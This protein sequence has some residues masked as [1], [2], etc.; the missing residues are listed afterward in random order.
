M[1]ILINRHW[2]QP[3]IWPLKETCLDQT[4][5]SWQAAQMIEQRLICGVCQRDQRESLYIQNCQTFWEL[6]LRIQ[7]RTNLSL[8]L[9]ARRINKFLNSKWWIWEKTLKNCQF[10][11]IS[12]SNMVHC[13]RSIPPQSWIAGLQKTSMLSMLPWLGPIPVMV[14]H[15]Y[16][17]IFPCIKYNC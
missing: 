12:L 8:R 7:V 1:T 13:L 14:P 4:L 16:S 9:H 17:K 3:R 2:F 15:H 10:C 11:Q 6:S 5:V